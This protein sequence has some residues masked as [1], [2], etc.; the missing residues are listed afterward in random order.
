MH[1][2]LRVHE[3][4]SHIFEVLHR[5]SSEPDEDDDDD[6]NIYDVWYPSRTDTLAALA[7][8]RK[9]FNYPA[10]RILWRD[11]PALFP[12]RFLMEPSDYEID[13]DDFIRTKITKMS[14]KF[15]KRLKFYAPLV[16]RIRTSC[17]YTIF[18]PSS[19]MLFSSI[20]AFPSPLFPNLERVE[21]NCHAS[22]PM[23]A[24][25]Y[26]AVVLGS[27]RLTDIT[28]FT[29]DQMVLD[30][31]GHRTTRSDK[32]QWEVFADRLLPFAHQLRR[33]RVTTQIDL[34]PLAAPPLTQLCGAFSESMTQLDVCSIE[35][36]YTTIAA[37]GSLSRLEELRITVND[38]NLGNIVMLDD[39]RLVFPTLRVLCV[40]T[41]AIDPCGAFF[42]KIDAGQLEQLDVRI[43]LAPFMFGEINVLP[44]LDPLGDWK[45]GR[46]LAQIRVHG[47]TL[48]DLNHARFQLAIADATLQRLTIFQ[49]ITEFTL[50]PCVHHLSDSGLLSAF[51]S[52][53]SLRHFELCGD[54]V[55][56]GVAQ[57]V[58]SLSLS[59]VHTAL[60]QCPRLAC[61]ALACDCRDLPSTADVQPHEK[62]S[63]WNVGHS[64]I[65]SGR[66]FAE[67]AV[68]S[69][70]KLRTVGYFN[71]LRQKV[72][73]NF[74][75][76]W[77]SV[78]QEMVY[79][80][81]WNDVPK[82]FKAKCNG[83]KRG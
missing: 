46:A 82:F 66:G 21:L 29:D 47:S 37:I 65:R 11:L 69:L 3:I 35:L 58:D 68:L 70:P 34:A 73:A 51:S 44:L 50:S 14:P 40:T 61:L 67:W 30:E 33:F 18:H 76:I 26:P 12:I 53:K 79:L 43:R 52:W 1:T 48:G 23:E 60:R 42:S 28:V 54:N 8:T 62:L 6:D 81:Q 20:P 22:D 72:L 56:A 16:K 63:R 71:A 41:T 55:C 27:S 2:C 32:T 4:V 38:R 80:A 5:L 10:T 39:S 74:D 45:C 25:F 36:P 24:L 83:R 77:P 75:S 64:P 49:N 78:R 7:R 31:F 19:L 9:T 17:D 57:E 13:D 15:L 59:G